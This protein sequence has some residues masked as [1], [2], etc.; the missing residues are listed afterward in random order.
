MTLCR[1]HIDTPIDLYRPLL[2][3][4]D[5]Y[6][7]LSTSTDLYWPLPTSTDLY[8]PLYLQTPHALS[9]MP[10]LC[11]WV[12]S[13]CMISAKLTAK[14]AFGSPLTLSVTCN[15][16]IIWIRSSCSSLSSI[17]FDSVAIFPRS[18]SDRHIG[19]GNMISEMRVKD[20]RWN[21]LC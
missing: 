4:T 10:L 1:Y 2:T 16:L 21:S 15:S 17:S 7:P 19:Q 20:I 3:P 18:T 13:S 9:L 14:N 5:L 12:S 8:W 11:L 6:W